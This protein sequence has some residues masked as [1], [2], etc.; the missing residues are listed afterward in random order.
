MNTG[1]KILLGAIGVTAAWQSLILVQENLERYSCYNMS[2]KLADEAG[3]PLLVIGMRR[4]SWQPPNESDKG[5][6]KPI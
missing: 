6:W 5:R 1:S 2:R 4:N 3:K